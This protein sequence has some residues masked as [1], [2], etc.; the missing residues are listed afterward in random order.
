MLDA[1]ATE[2]YQRHGLRVA[3]RAGGVG[4]KGVGAGTQLLDLRAL[5]GAWVDPARG[6][7]LRRVGEHATAMSRRDLPWD[8]TVS[9]TWTPMEDGAPPGA[10]L[11]GYL[12]DLA[13]FAADPFYVNSLFDEPEHVAAAYNAT[14]WARLG[15]L[16]RHWDP[17]TLFAGHLA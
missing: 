9:T 15:R 8:Y 4:W 13:P 11:D 1:C 2:P 12:A 3:L 10:W 6:T 17:D 5:D 7:V 14:T 16:K